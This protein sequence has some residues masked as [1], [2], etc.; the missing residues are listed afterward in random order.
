MLVIAVQLW[1]ATAHVPLAEMTRNVVLVVHLQKLGNGCLG[2]GQIGT[3]AT[4]ILTRSGWTG[5]T[6]TPGDLV[7]VRANPDKNAQ[8][9]HALLSTIEKEDGTVLSARSYFLRRAD[10]AQSLASTSDLS[11]R[12][13]M[14]FS[15]YD[16]YY[17]SWADVELTEAL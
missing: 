8:R 10:D 12:W 13:E 11:G 2:F 5:E 15:D 7:R 4:P 3:D 17:A 9:Q 16:R 1:R 6:F 14:R